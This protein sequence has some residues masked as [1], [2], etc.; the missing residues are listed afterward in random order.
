MKPKVFWGWV[1]AAGIFLAIIGGVLA[2]IPPL[3]LSFMGLGFL[4]MLV[5]VIAMIPIL[6]KEMKRDDQDMRE[7]IKEEDLRP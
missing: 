1:V 7:N 4:M 2:I 3:G 6:I 5:G